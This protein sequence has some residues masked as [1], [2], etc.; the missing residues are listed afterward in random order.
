MEFERRSNLVVPLR[1]TQHPF[2]PQINPLPVSWLYKFMGRGSY[3]TG[4]LC[5]QYIG[6]PSHVGALRPLATHAKDNV[7]C[8]RIRNNV[9]WFTLTGTP[10]SPQRRASTIPGC[11]TH[12]SNVRGR[13]L[14]TY[15]IRTSRKQRILRSCSNV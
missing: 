7:W 13:F 4:H 3:F 1:L 9:V 12:F 14:D 8:W 2:E 11:S 10:G 5:P 6:H 15:N